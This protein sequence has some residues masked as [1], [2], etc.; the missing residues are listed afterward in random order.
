MKIFGKLPLILIWQW[1]M[2]E[3]KNKEIKKSQLRRRDSIYFTW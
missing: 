2:K 1:I 3:I